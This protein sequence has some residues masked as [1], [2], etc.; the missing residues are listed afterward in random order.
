MEQVTS[1]DGTRI[2]YWRSGGGPPLLLVHGTTADHSRWGP[3][4]PLLEP[5]FTVYLMD[6]RGRSESSDAPEYSL[7]REAEDVAAVV[8]SIGKPAF[9]LG[10]SYGGLCSL[11]AALLTDNVKRLI[12]YE[13]VLSI[14]KPIY[15]PPVLDRIQTLV[16]RGELEPALEIFFRDIVEMPPARLAEFRQLPAWP[17]RV[18]LAPTIARELVVE[19][20][21]R[22]DAARLGAFTRPALLL[23]GGD[24][25][26]FFHNMARH[27]HAALPDSRLVVM[28][29]QGHNAMDTAPELFVREV[30]RFLEG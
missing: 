30:R 20:M 2:A 15:S 27:V 21:Y 19:E 1:R 9:V 26:G 8:E 22:F 14:G 29:G 24:S 5:H 18:T 23:L 6:R 10:H 13:P 28:P 4:L 17:V 16:D 3:L 25:A 11:E 7:A 12:L